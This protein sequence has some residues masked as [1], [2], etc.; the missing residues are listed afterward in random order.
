MERGANCLI[1]VAGATTAVTNSAIA[2]LIEE[3]GR[4]DYA[5]DIWGA[6]AGI[7]GLLDG[8]MIDLGAQKRKVVEGLRRT[9]GSVLSGAHRVLESGEGAAFHRG[10]A[11]RRNRRDFPVGRLARAGIGA[12]FRGRRDRSRLCAEHALRSFVERKRSRCRRSQSGIW[13]DGAL[14]RFGRARCRTRGCIGRRTA[15]N[16]RNCGQ[17]LW[18]GGGFI[19]FGARRTKPRAARRSDTR[20]RG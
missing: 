14:C 19:G 2:G 3:A 11:T 10:F 12:L 18:L 6:S 17:K 15:A 7:G 16:R 8:K 5:A 9:P 1:V 4:G 13:L 20:S